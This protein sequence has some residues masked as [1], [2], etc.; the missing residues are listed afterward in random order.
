MEQTPAQAV[1]FVEY[2]LRQVCTNKEAIDLT[3][4][5]DERGYLVSVRVDSSDMGKLIGRNGKTVDSIRLLVRSI[6]TRLGQRITM[7]VIDPTT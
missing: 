4:D 7:K 2:L 3:G 1:T 5:E 6:G